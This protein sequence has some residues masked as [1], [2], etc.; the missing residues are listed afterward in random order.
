ME[1]E[2]KKDPAQALEVAVFQ[3]GQEILSQEQQNPFFLV[4]L[5]GL[6]MLSRNGKT[7]RTLGEQDIFGLESLLLREPSHYAA[8]AVQKCRIARYGPETLDYLIHESPRMIQN[9]LVSILHQLTQTALSLLDSPQPFPVDR[10]CVRFY[11]DGES[12]LEET[13]GGTEIF[14][15]ISTQGGLQV[16]VGGREITRIKRPGEFFGFPFPAITPA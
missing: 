9:V 11:Q 16:T 1:K 13:N 4:I 14:R 12:I 7:I 5:S 10:E 3:K 2:I 8:Q 15:L 6:V